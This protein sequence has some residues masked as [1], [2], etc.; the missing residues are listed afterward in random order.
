MS[1]EPI[2]LEKFVEEIIMDL[3]A[4][5]VMFVGIHASSTRGL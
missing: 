3:M 4:E 5:R 1:G 2:A